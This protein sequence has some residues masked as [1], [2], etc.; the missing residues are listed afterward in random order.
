MMEWQRK[1]SN[2]RDNVVADESVLRP[3]YDEKDVN[4][5]IV[6]TRQDTVMVV[7]LLN[8]VNS[9]LA[10]VKLLLVILISLVAFSLFR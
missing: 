3:D 8:S 9:N 1:A 2:L 4:Q 7:S 6:H 10:G 5:A